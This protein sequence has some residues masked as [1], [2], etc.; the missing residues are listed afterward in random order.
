M[1]PALDELVE[2]LREADRQERIE[3]LIDLA[4]ELPPLPDRLSQYKDEAHRVPECQSPVFLFLE[5]EGAR[6]HLFADVPPEAPTV[7]GFVCLLV[8]GL[9]G[10][11]VEDVL[12][13]PNDLIQRTGM[14]EILGMQRTS[15][16]SGVLHRLKAMVA[17]T[18]AAST[19]QAQQ[20]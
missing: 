14:A 18:E 5:R 19:N 11:T 12:N 4:N 8:R 17:R 3:L 2:E 15:G 1:P 10:A 13:V 7:R 6:I 9:D 20:N 16:L